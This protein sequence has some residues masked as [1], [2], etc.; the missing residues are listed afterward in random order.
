MS[1][2]NMVLPFQITKF[3]FM[4][5]RFLL[6]CFCLS[7]IVHSNAQTG[8]L[9]G[10]IKDALSGVE[11][12]NVQVSVKGTDISSTS[13]AEG[14]YIVNE[15]EPQKYTFIVSLP[16]YETDTFKFNILGGTISVYNIFLNPVIN[17]FDEARKV[18][19]RKRKKEDIEIGNTKI[20]PANLFKIPTVGGTPDL[21]QYLQILPGVVFSGDQ[22][23][24]LYIRGGSPVMNKILLDGMTIYNPFHS[25]GLFS[26]FDADL[27]KSADVYSAGFGAEHGGRVSAIV[28]VKTRDGNRNKLSG[29]F[30][31]S[32]FLGKLSLEGPLKKFIPGRGSSSFIVSIKNSFL[33]QSSKIF[34]QYA[35]PDKLPYSFND[36]YGKITFNSPNGSSIKLFGFNFRDNVNFPGSTSYSWNQ[37][38]ASARFTLIPEGKQSKIDAFIAYSD[39]DIQQKEID[40]RPRQS[41]ISGLNMGVNALGYNKKDEIKYGFE[42][43]A[44]STYFNIY[45][46]NN[47]FISQ[48]QFTTEIC[49]FAL[50]KWVRKRFALEAGTR[51]QYYAS[52]GNTSLEPRINGKYLIN[53]KLTLKGGIGRYSQNLLSAFSDRDV[54][55]L[56]YGFLS[57][58]D[59]LPKQFDGKE[60]KSRLQLARQAVFGFDYDISKYMDFGIEGFYKSFDQITNINRDKLFD[61][62]G[63]YSVFPERLKKD[64]LIEKGNAYGGD[65]KFKFDDGKKWFVWAVYSLTYVSRNDGFITYS[66]HWDRRHNAN[67]VVDYVFDKKG[68]ISANVRWNF[69]SGFPFTQTTGFYEKFDFQSGPS[70][71]YMQSNGQLGILYGDL[72]GG[73]L[74]TYHRLD[75]SVRYNLRNTKKFKSHVVL[76]VTNIYNRQNVFYFDRVNFTRVNQLPIMPALSYSASF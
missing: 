57:G 58:P 7:V 11:L 37:T 76:S 10:F 12:D 43:N 64:F 73:R 50:Y 30:S 66:P 38:G 46:S 19:I 36:V 49:G 18:A 21:V 8:G 60:V 52:L 33:D 40:L 25:I 5:L 44:F 41:S 27:M 9:K 24:Q 29:N 51:L 55:N 63:N 67:I 61:D 23:G 62:D 2:T 59:N 74:P 4:F 26:I 72:N 53:K 15:L 13:N 3:A 28:D 31:L 68:K 35:D 65:F 75:A 1:K 39:Y 22:G 56:F 69:G 14:Y 70:F 47:R 17:S 54:V 32:P 34:Y 48:E 6:L 16:G 45:N 42:I 71:N 20:K